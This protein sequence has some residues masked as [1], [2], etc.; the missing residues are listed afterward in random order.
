MF[1]WEAGTKLTRPRLMNRSPRCGD[2]HKRG[3]LEELGEQLW[4]AHSVL[5]CLEPED[6]QSAIR[7][8]PDGTA[9]MVN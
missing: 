6:E 1:G 8:K 7:Y 5:A 9:N 2:V 4:S 3:H